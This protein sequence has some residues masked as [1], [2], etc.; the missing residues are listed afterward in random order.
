MNVGLYLKCEK[1]WHHRPF[2]PPSGR[3]GSSRQLPI[4]REAAEQTDSAVR[5]STAHQPPAAVSSHGKRQQASRAKRDNFLEARD[6]ALAVR[7]SGQQ[8]PRGSDEQW[9][10]CDSMTPAGPGRSSSRRASPLLRALAA[11]V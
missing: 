8:E 10:Q 9:R 4:S 5:A 11:L 7:S 1:C 2:L 6:D 3:V